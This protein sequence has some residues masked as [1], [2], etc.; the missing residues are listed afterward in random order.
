MTTWKRN[1]Y[2]AWEK[3]IPN[4]PTETRKQ[5]NHL[6]KESQKNLCNM[7]GDGFIMRTSMKN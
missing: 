4:T 1:V 2:I 7:C 6:Q 3:R 5:R